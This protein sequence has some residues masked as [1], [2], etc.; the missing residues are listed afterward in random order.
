MT[1][2]SA[3]KDELL[4]AVEFFAAVQRYLVQGWGAGGL[5]GSPRQ[6]WERAVIVAPR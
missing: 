3:A 1:E 6:R 5:K 4:P 2:A